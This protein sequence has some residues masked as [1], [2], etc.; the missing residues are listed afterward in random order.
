[1][2]K[3]NVL[4]RNTVL[5]LL[6]I[7]S[8]L[9]LSSAA[10]YVDSQNGNDLSTGKTDVHAWKT[11]QKVNK[12]ALKA[13]DTVYLKAN[14][15]WTEQLYIRQSGDNSAPIV[16]TKYGTG[17]RPI[18]EYPNKPRFTNAVQLGGSYITIDNIHIQN[19]FDGGISTWSTCDYI[20]VQNCEINNCGCGIHFAGQYCL[21][22]NNYLHDMKIVVNTPD[23]EDDDN[24]ALGV[25]LSNSNNEICYNR[26]V[27]C[28]DTS[29]DYKYDGGAIEIWADK[30][31]KNIKVHHNDVYRC[32]GFFEIGGK[33]KAVESI[34]V[35]YNLLVDCF[36]LTFL[37]FNTSGQYAILLDDYLFANNTIVSHDCPN[38]NQWA[39]ISAGNDVPPGSFTMKNNLF[40]LWKADR[41]MG[42]M[43]NV[44]SDNNMI[45]VKRT[46]FFELG[47]TK[48]ATDVF[49]VDPQLENPGNCSAEGDYRLKKTSPARDVG[50]DI[51]LSLN[52]DMSGIKVPFGNKS[53]I[54]AFEYS[55]IASGTISDVKQR[56]LI[57]TPNPIYKGLLVNKDGKFSYRV[58]NVS[59]KSPVSYTIQGRAGS[60]GNHAKR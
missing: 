1:M 36:G 39:C 23:I 3:I 34:D 38:E 56:S 5:L 30:D 43:K 9:F 18:I 25:L 16:I 48:A 17:E 8:Q 47:Y 12:T 29:Y 28:K 59:G 46:G 49:G 32:C 15:K 2:L 22:T 13:G 50:V 35:Y 60:F 57:M 45:Y 52:Y 4:T 42:N 20:T 41:V 27:N 11:L 24:G 44:I 14:C 58:M 6:L 53:D 19:V 37:Y 55:D 7:L 51:G 31:I 40:Y 26:F 33:G 21:A 54:G 10:Y